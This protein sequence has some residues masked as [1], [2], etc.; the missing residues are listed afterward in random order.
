MSKDADYGSQHRLLHI[1]AGF[2]AGQIALSW[3]ITDGTQRGT[4]DSYS[5]ADVYRYFTCTVMDKWM[6]SK[7]DAI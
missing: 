1:L 3:L 4:L 5:Q 2:T 7:T 6:L